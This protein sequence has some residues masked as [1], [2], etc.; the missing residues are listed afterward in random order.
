MDTGE[1]KDLFDHEDDL[2][3]DPFGDFPVGLDEM[4]LQVASASYVPPI[5]TVCVPRTHTFPCEFWLNEV[6]Q[7]LDGDILGQPLFRSRAWALVQF[8]AVH[9]IGHRNLHKA[10]VSADRLSPV[11][12]SNLEDILVELRK[13][14]R[15]EHIRQVMSIP[16]LTRRLLSFFVVTYCSQVPLGYYVDRSIYPPRMIG[17]LGQRYQPEIQDR[18]RKKES[19]VWVDLHD[20][21]VIVR[22][23]SNRTLNPYC[24]S[25]IVH[26][27]EFG[28][29]VLCV[30]NF[31]IWFISVAGPDVFNHVKDDVCVR[32]LAEDKRQ[33]LKRRITS[34]PV[35]ADQ[36][37]R[38]NPTHADLLQRKKRVPLT[39]SVAATVTVGTEDQTAANILRMFFSN[40]KVMAN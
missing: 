14:G 26:T 9:S 10:S 17:Q 23:N 27:E 25:T 15:A 21:Y 39:R 32:K 33:R 5:Q 2:S 36:Y 3:D 28:D 29:I 12:R 38:G 16:Y 22:G 20:E 13:P 30:H 19:V 18:I 24:R 40:D 11:E 8:F 6:F 4:Q 31:Y 7:Y 34:D 1:E 35:Q 37:L